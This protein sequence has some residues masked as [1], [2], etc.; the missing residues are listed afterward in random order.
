VEVFLGEGLESF[1]EFFL[2]GMLASRLGA[3]EKGGGEE[4]QGARIP[5]FCFLTRTNFYKN[6]ITE[7][8]LFGEGCLW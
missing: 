8:K 4:M 2:V 6:R 5:I 7:S 3:R 1:L